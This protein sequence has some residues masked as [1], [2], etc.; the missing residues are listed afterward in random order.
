MQEKWAYALKLFLDAIYLNKAIYMY[1][2]C[3][4]K[5]QPWHLF[6]VGVRNWVWGGAGDSIFNLSFIYRTVSQMIDNIINDYFKNVIKFI[7]SLIISYQ[8]SVYLKSNL[9]IANLFWCS[10]PVTKY[11]LNEILFFELYRK[12]KVFRTLPERSEKI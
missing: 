10:G 12:Q 5:G 9:P 1:Y 2:T 8:I 4:L 7:T 6:L 11:E 3:H